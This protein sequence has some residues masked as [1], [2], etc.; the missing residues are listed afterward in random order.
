MTCIKLSLGLFAIR[1]FFVFTTWCSSVVLSQITFM[2]LMSNIASETTEARRYPWGI[3]QLV[4]TNQLPHKSWGAI[5]TNSIPKSLNLA[6][7]PFSGVGEEGGVILQT[8]SNPKSGQIVT[9]EGGYSRPTQIPSAK[10]WPYFHF[11]GWGV[12]Q[13]NIPEKLEWGH[14][15]NFE[16]KILEA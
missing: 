1:I 6:K 9:W 4:S 12:L 15:R 5:H 10:S 16:P 13:T 8:N 2:C 14:S 3:Q 11:R 7:L